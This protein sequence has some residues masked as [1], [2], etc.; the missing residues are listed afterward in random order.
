M[1][2]WKLQINQASNLWK[3][4]LN[5]ILAGKRRNSR[6]SKIN[7]LIIRGIKSVFDQRVL[8]EIYHNLFHEYKTAFGFDPP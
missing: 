5:V 3:W 6:G 1:N 8:L 2:S 4:V 7:W